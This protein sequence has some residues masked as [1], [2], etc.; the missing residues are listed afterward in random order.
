MNCIA[1]VCQHQ[2]LITGL[3]AG[4]Q[5]Y[6]YV[7]STDGV[8]NSTTD[9]NSNSYY[10][11][12]TTLDTTP[13]VISAISVPVMA[14]NEAVIV[15]TTDEPATSQVLYGTATGDR[16]KYSVTDMTKSI[17]H[18]VTLSPETTNAGPAG[19]TNTLTEKTPYYYVV[20]SAD[21]AGNT[22]TSP[23]Q[24]FT[25]PS[26]GNVTVVA[27]SISSN[28]GASNNPT[29]DTTP[30][31]ISDIKATSID[32]FDE[33]IS[34]TTNENTVSF[35]DYGK[36]TSYGTTFGDSTLASSHSTK[37]INLTMGTTY[38][39]RV[40]AIDAAG[41]TTT[42]DDQTFKTPFLSEQTSTST[43]PLDDATLLQSK[44]EDLVQS[45]LPSL[46]APFI[47]KPV[48]TDITEHEAKI[49]FTS[50]VKAYGLVGYTNDDEYVLASSTDAYTTELS[51]GSG[52]ETTHTVTLKNLK[53]NTKYHLQAK[54]YVFQDVVGKSDDVTFLTKPSQ[55]QG[56]IV[57]RTKSSFTVVWT[58]DEPASSIIEYRDKATGITQKNSDETLKTA[59]SIKVEN[60]VSGDTYEVNISGVNKTG[61]VLEAVAPLTVTVPRDLI[62]PVIS[63]FKVDGTLVP[64]RTDRIQ[65]VVS[66]KTDK[67]ADSTVYYEEGT[68]TL[69]DTKELANKIS[70][71]EVFVQAHS[72]ILANLKPGTIYR[73]KIVSV[74]DSGNRASFGPRTIITPQQ[75]QSITDIIFKNFEDSFKFLRNF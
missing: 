39:Y 30:P 13:P 44:I 58:T 38:H 1:N 16:S 11:F 43:V 47:T 73:I 56:S 51:T 29:P 24:T 28:T 67:I 17:Y 45:A 10:T 53:S 22:A 41:N 52:R 57:E 37:L 34:F 9:T 15:W 50:N 63:G 49:T 62:P 65:T 54:A 64:G 7:K 40:K 5:Y 35:V 32:S 36:D 59:H 55:I 21:V 48:V 23:E 61:N 3:T 31:T 6:Y 72:V 70:S 19:G 60:L 14:S 46:T 4:V 68:G 8:G 2:V 69:G 74:D 18:V 20:K 26:S 75:T 71:A 12:T 25:T 42:S 66:W 27:V 33:A